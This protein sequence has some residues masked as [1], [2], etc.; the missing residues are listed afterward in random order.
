M[1]A[2]SPQYDVRRGKRIGFGERSKGYVL[3]SP[4]TEARSAASAAVTS[5]TGSVKSMVPS[6]TARE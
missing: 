4:M 2:T 5:S 3:R 6:T 1:A